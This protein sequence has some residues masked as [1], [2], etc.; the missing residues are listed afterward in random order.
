[1]YLSVTKISLIIFALL[2]SPTSRAEKRVE[3]NVLNYVSA[4]SSLHFERVLARGDVFNQW[5][6]NRILVPISN[7]PQSVRRINRDTLY[8]YAV[9]DISKGA[10]FSLPESDGHY[11]S[12]QV[13]N[14]KHFTNRTYYQAGQHTL[15][16][17]E[18][19]TSH[20]LL[21][22]RTLIDASDPEDIKRAHSLQNKLSVSSRSDKP[23]SPTS[24]D[25]QSLSEVTKTL[26]SLSDALPDANLCFGKENEVDK[27]RHLLATAYG[28]GGLPDA[29][30]S[31]TNVQPNLP[32]GTYSLTVKDVPVDGFWSIS[33]Y[34]KDGFF[35]KNKDDLYS[36]NNLAA[37]PNKDGSYTINFGGD[38]SKANYLP[39]T[40]GWN[41][42]ARMYRPRQSILDGSWVFPL[43]K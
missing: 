26:L 31:Y 6:H 3:V 14:Q 5:M 9:V 27:V 21:L 22:A 25:S 8:S 36:I 16:T 40:E 28:W 33:V 13:I 35:E 19:D 23:Y 20:V 12:V 7:K 30:A 15:S 41:Y 11:F 37:V 24:Y 38:P 29:E 4:K 10:S 32:I 39:I 2:L 43:A 42:V 17:A 1:M 18:F 34:N